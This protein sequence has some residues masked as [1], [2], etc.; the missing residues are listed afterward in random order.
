MK[1]KKAL[2][3]SAA[4]LL[5][6]IIH[7]FP[8]NTIRCGA[9][10]VF[11]STFAASYSYV[12][13]KSGVVYWLM[14]APLPVFSKAYCSTEQ[15][16]QAG[17][18]PGVSETK[19][20]LS[21]P[22]IDFPWYLPGAVQKTTPYYWLV[23]TDGEFHAILTDAPIRGQAATNP[24]RRIDVRIKKPRDYNPPAQ[25]GLF[26]RDSERQCVFVTKTPGG[27]DIYQDTRHK[28]T[29][30]TM[31]KGLMVQLEL[32]NYSDS[33]FLRLEGADV[34]EITEIVDGFRPLTEK[35]RENVE[36]LQNSREEPK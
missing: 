10:P 26:L 24:K 17:F 13:P 35:E 31:H 28:D 5:I 11:T 29:F 15:A 18:R 16:E 20:T 19:I 1:H 7:P 21:D 22:T 27:H 33:G 25:C 23:Y 32:E 4:V 30:Y 9:F 34:A 2:I 3:A 14:T 8:R 6:L 12:S 36:I